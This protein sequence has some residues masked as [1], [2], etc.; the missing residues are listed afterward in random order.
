MGY[1]FWDVMIGR[2]G[3]FGNADDGGEKSALNP[4]PEFKEDPDYRKTQDYLRDLGIDILGGDIPD[5]YAGI[6][7]PGGAEF[8]NYLSLMTGDIQKSALETSAALGRGGGRA[9]E[10]ASKDVGEFSTKARYADFMRAMEGK[11]WLFGEGKDIT[12]GVRSSG[13]AQGAQE[14]AFNLN[15][16]GKEFDRS[17]YQDAQDQSFWESLFG[18][19]KTAVGAGVGFAQ[20]GP[21]GAVAGAMG[22]IDWEKILDEAGGGGGGTTGTPASKK[23]NLGK[24]G[25]SDMNLDKLFA[26]MFR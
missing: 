19:G 4:L 8:E 9:M 20:G 16:A 21:V 13:Q 14:N 12:E 2:Q 11:Q 17:R 1:N 25:S 26:D 24:I 15:I 3:L 6:G 22:G 5:Y 7:Q 23:V 10:V 18:L